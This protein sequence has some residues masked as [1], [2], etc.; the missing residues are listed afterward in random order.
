MNKYF[1]LSLLLF[2]L[3]SCKS[4]Q[5]TSTN[6]GAEDANLNKDETHLHQHEHK[7]D[8]HQHGHKH[9][10]DH[11]HQHNASSN[12]ANTSTVYKS[13]INKTAANGVEYSIFSNGEKGQKA[14][15]QDYLT[16]HLKYSTLQDSVIYSSYRQ[17][18][19][20]HFKFSET[21]FRG[22]LSE[23]IT[24]MQPGDSSVFVVPAEMMYPTRL[25]S[26]LKKGE[27]LKYHLKLIDL[28]DPS[29]KEK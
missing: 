15:L 19:P 5:G 2:C 29:S 20:I 21:L 14:R 13:T 17:K 4:D 6:K 23:G 24:Q 26:F 25:P 11:S 8:S 10:G 1:F 7:G 12:A 27:K 18:V 28:E 3:F 16:V 22:V 9:D